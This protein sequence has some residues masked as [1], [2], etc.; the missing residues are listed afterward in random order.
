MSFVFWLHIL[1][2]FR[3]RTIPGFSSDAAESITTIT[4]KQLEN[5]RYKKANGGFSHEFGT[6]S[7]LLERR[8]FYGR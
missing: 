4:Y 5:Q 3:R 1:A 6:S 2:L 8:H 7:C